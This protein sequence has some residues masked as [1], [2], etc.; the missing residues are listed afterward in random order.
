MWPEHRK[1]LINT[2]GERERA[3]VLSS[4]AQYTTYTRIVLASASVF[5]TE[6]IQPING[7]CLVQYFNR[8]TS[9]ILHL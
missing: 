9:D 1:A 6:H 8:L 2:H 4:A 5:W 7:V 3:Y